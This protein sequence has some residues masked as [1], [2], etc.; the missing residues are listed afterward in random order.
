M[1]KSIHSHLILEYTDPLTR[2]PNL[3]QFLN[4]FL[5]L[6]L[7][8]KNTSPVTLHTLFNSVHFPSLLFPRTTSSTFRIP[9]PC[10][11]LKSSKFN[12]PSQT[13][14]L[15]FYM[16]HRLLVTSLMIAFIHSQVFVAYLLCAKNGLIIEMNGMQNG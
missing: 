6:S 15:K 16:S 7:P 14:P 10:L 12:F 4:H 13:I 8:Q 3:T 2:L 11:K 1:L 9:S 5:P